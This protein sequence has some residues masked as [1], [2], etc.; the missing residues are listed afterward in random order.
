MQKFILSIDQ[1]T[2]SSRAILFDESGDVHCQ[3]QKEFT[4]YFPK[5]GYVLH[6]ANEIWD[7]VSG[8]ISD[9]LMKAKVSADQIVAIGITNQR[10][11]T[12]MWDKKTGKPVY[13]AI[14]WQSKQ[15][16]QI[17][18]QLKNDGWETTIHEKTGLLIDSYFSGTKAKW[19]LDNVPEAKT[20][21]DEK[22]LLFGTIDSWLIWNL[23][24]GNRHV[25]DYTNA[26]RTLMFDINDLRWDDDLMGLFG[27]TQAMLP[28]VVPSSSI[29]GKTAKNVFYGNEIPISGVAGDQQAALFGQTCFNTGDVKSTYGTGCFI[30][31][32]TGEEP[33][34]SS[35][36][37]LTTVAWNIEGKTKY[38]LE[39]SIFV[40][41]SAVQWLRD[42]IKVIKTSAE[43]E[44][45]AIACSSTEGVYVVPAFT[46][47][48]TPYWDDE[49]KGAIFGITRGTTREHLIRATLESIAFQ[50]NDVIHV[51]EDECGLEL[52][53]LR[54]DGGASQ[55][56]FLMQFQSD[57]LNNQIDK[58]KTS[59]TTALGAAYLAG[60]AVGFWT[61]EDIKKM[62]KSEKNFVPSMD[63]NKRSYLY[64][65]W[66]KAVKACMNFHH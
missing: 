9:C 4:Q 39:G 32:N 2:T 15:T 57:I 27:V 50:T 3:S 23:T 8:C 19:I 37:L 38:A 53:H 25:T 41:G 60:L 20:L 48:G 17:C 16:N 49:A 33:V 66:K 6:D 54:V 22:R 44:T 43:S 51:M 40:A 65:G 12:V 7:S 28:E 1:G 61:I 63:E 47:L 24:D 34:F 45:Y 5:P 26:S 11:T 14:V 58:P 59:E 31:M 42:G 35:E 10:E 52:N 64:E 30:L 56:D 46:G 62:W 36:G 13:K 18:E 55:N 29:L 21:A